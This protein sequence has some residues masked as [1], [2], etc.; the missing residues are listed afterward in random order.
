MVTKYSQSEWGKWEKREEKTNRGFLALKKAVCFVKRTSCSVCTTYG[1][2][3]HT[4]MWL[5][6]EGRNAQQSLVV[7]DLRT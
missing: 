3:W 2:V 5:L 1:D 6:V 4:R 7:H